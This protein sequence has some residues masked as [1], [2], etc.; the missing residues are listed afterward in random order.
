[1]DR[2]NF[3]I[4]NTVKIMSAQHPPK[5]IGTMAATI[6]PNTKIKTEKNDKGTFTCTIT[7]T[8]NVE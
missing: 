1:M 2:K 8:A 7:I 4:R 3:P 6:A 5:I